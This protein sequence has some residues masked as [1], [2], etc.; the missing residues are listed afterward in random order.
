VTYSFDPELAPLAAVMPPANFDDPATAR[1]GMRALFARMP[2]YQPPRP[3]TVED[4][5]VPGSAGAPEVPVRVYA[6]AERGGLLGGLLYFTGAGSSPGIWRPHTP[7][8]HSSPQ[9]PASW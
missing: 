9:R 5:T 6:P 8:R 1:A 3:L 7:R 2:A 4:V